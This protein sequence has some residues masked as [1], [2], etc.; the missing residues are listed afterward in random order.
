MATLPDEQS[1]AWERTDTSSR[2]KGQE[3]G[4]Y[5]DNGSEGDVGLGE[6][7]HHTVKGRYSKQLQR[8]P[9]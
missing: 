5:D 2:S 3:K 1:A 4:E 6:D 9:Q 7:G 8:L